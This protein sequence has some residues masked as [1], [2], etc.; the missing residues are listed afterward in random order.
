MAFVV[1]V[2]AASG[3]ATVSSTPRVAAFR[4]HHA[5]RATPERRLQIDLVF[6]GQPISP[7]LEAAA[8]EEVIGIWT[9][10]GVDVRAAGDSGDGPADAVNSVSSSSIA[11]TR[12]RP[13]ALSA[14]FNS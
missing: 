9:A 11:R 7:E 1:I 6:S 4:W 3:A 5:G 2:S 12:P 10:Y 14:R 13:Q 8:M